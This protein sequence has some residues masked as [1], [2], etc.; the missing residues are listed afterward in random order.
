MTTL[1]I[2]KT[3]KVGILVSSGCYNKIPQ[4][5]WLINNSI[6]FSQLWKWESPKLRQIQSSVRPT[7]WLTASVFFL[8][9]HRVED[10]A[11]SLS[12]LS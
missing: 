6:Y 10:G 9:P 7:I 5:G 1:T 11:T 4:T 2:A 12:S 8:R 3:G